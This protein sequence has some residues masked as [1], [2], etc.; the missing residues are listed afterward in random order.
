[1]LALLERAVKDAGGSY[2]FMDTD[3]MAIV[4][5]ETGGLV[6]CAGGPHRTDAG[7]PAVKALAWHQIEEICDAFGALNPYDANIVPGSVLEIEDENYTKTGKQR[8]LHCYAISSK[9]YALYTLDRD[10]RPQLRQTSKQET[11]EKWTEHGLGHLLN[12]IDPR[13][14]DRDWVRQFWQDELDHIYGRTPPKRDWATRPAIGTVSITKPSVLAAFE[15]RNSGKSYA[16]SIKPFN[17]LIT[18]HTSVENRPSGTAGFQLVAPWTDEPDKWLE[19]DWVDKN[20]SDGRTY[21]AVTG[22]VENP[23]AQ[24]KIKTVTDVLADYR[25]HPEPKSLAP[26]GTRSGWH[27]TGLLQR[28]PVKATRLVLVGKE[29]NEL[30]ETTAGLALAPDED[31]IGYAR[32]DRDWS[33]TIQP[34]LARM[35]LSLLREQSEMGATALKNLRAGK[36]RKSHKRDQLAMIAGDWA[37]DQLRAAGVEPPSLATDRCAAYLQELPSRPAKTCPVCGKP[38]DNPRATYCSNACK[39][40]A[41]RHRR[42]H[43]RD[44]S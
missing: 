39:Q 43:R 5:T 28:R 26:D 4:A 10:G 33:H 25:V 2:C 30:E 29:S 17:F 42:H 19:S 16:E 18:A 8:Q 7:E 24:I 38:V 3:S 44:L 37:A 11:G 31:T 9:R 21:Q 40:Q 13:T 36:S 15:Q 1:M 32:G 27:T 22:D 20:T 34:V 12:P 6:P 35:P 14:K 23:A 41:H